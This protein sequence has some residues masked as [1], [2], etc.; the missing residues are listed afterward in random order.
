M[1]HLKLRIDEHNA[2]WQSFFER[3]GIEPLR[4]VYEEFVEAYEDNVLGLLDGLEIPLPE[5]FTVTQPRMKRQADEL[6]EEWVRLYNE[7]KA[8]GTGGRSRKG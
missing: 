2:A 5:G 7:R 8:A 3:G 4:I 1:D 6:S